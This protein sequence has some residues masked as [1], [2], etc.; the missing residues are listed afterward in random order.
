MTTVAVTKCNSYSEA[1]VNNALCKVCDI[2]G[3]PDVKGKK[4]LLKPNI[5]SD[6]QPSDSITTNPMVVRQ[7]IRYCRDKGASEIYVGDSPGMQ[8]SGFKPV[9]SG[10][11][12]VCVEEGARWV[13]F[14][15]KPVVKTLETVGTKVPVASIVDEADVIIGLCKM[16]NHQLMYVTGA[17][18]NFFGVIPTIN[19]SQCHLKFQSREAFAR[20]LVNLH[21]TVKPD[22][23]IMDAVI[24]MEGPG[25]AN[26]TP[27]KTCL[28][29]AS[30][31][32]YALD[33]AQAIIMGYD[34]TQLPLLSEASNQHLIPQEVEYPDLDPRDL[35]I[36][37]FVRIPYR[38]KTQF[39]SKLIL[40]FFG[41]WIEG[42]KQQKEQKP[43][44]DK[45]KCIHC[46][47]CVNICPGSALTFNKENKCI[48]PDYKKCIRCYCCH[49]MCPV[50][51]IEIKGRNND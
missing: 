47:K 24:S 27:R 6:A 18:K 17:V 35:I 15:Q 46:L 16:K 10:I 2:S 25:P 38:K 39:F 20:M 44:F 49:E 14:T 21:E 50:A 23:S 33:Q 22:F 30:E 3:F 13:D 34:P 1:E 36:K 43:V 12:A 11:Y 48:V 45:E 28:L 32:D 51:A 4:V 19:K 42:K 7:A 29:L 8:N 9:K 41:R 5:L 31:N 26:G 40:P 37:D